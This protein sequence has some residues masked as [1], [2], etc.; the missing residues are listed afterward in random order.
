MQVLVTV[1][2][3]SRHTLNLSNVTFTINKENPCNYRTT[4]QM[5][6]PPL[7][8]D[9]IFSILQEVVG[10]GTWVSKEMSTNLILPLNNFD[11]AQTG[12]I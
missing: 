3:D 11:S 4:T 8:I 7:L 12:M 2:K 6:P 9:M 10:K 1:T 5:L